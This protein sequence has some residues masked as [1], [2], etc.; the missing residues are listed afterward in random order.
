MRI[1]GI[2]PG[3][4]AEK[5]GLQ[6]GD[7]ITEFNGAKINNMMD[8]TVALGGAKPGQAVAVKILRDGKPLEFK[9]TLAAR[10]D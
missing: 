2:T 4:P 10:K 3:S 9:A 8:Y 6:Q 1:G 7:L 5:A